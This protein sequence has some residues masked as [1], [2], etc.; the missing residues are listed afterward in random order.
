MAQKD[1]TELCRNFC[2][3]Y[4]PSKN[5][6]IKC[7]GYLVVR[8]LTKKGKDLDLERTDVPLDDG[9]VRI[10]SE[11]L[12]SSCSFY[13]NDCD[14]AAHVESAPPCGGFIFLVHLINK[15]II[16]VEDVLN[17]NYNGK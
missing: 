14:F 7:K 2:H 10:L 9:T 3:Y 4:K 1:L 16:R 11:N 8:E 12:C 17:P 13:E 6:E 5:E 15:Q